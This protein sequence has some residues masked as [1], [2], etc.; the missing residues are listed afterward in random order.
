MSSAA[1]GLTAIVHIDS[2]PDDEL[3]GDL[4]VRFVIRSLEGGQRAV[5]KD[6]APAIGHVGGI[7]FEDG[8]IVR[9]VGLFDEQAAIESGR[10][11][12]ENGNLHRVLLPTPASTSASRS[13]CAISGMAGKSTSSSQPASSYPR[14]NW[15]MD[16][17]LV[18]S[19]A[20]ILSANGPVKA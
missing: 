11:S 19:P 17:G 20:A 3:V 5:R 8:D 13:S 16:W 4:L 7:A 15:A 2:V 1:N 9:G 14:M 18:S 6:H 12:A 10:A